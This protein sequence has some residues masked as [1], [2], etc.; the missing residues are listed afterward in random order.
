MTTILISA[1]DLSGETHAADFV[2]ALRS[3]CPEARFVGMGGAAMAEAGVELIV[4][5]RAIAV[6]GIVE[7]LGSVGRLVRAWLAR[8]AHSL[9][10]GEGV[11]ARR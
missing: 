3:R 5:Q 11:E 2:R 10:H 1:G 8:L 6:G 9:E 7:L 4:D